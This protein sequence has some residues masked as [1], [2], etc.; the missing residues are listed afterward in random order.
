MKTVKYPV[1]FLL[2]FLLLGPSVSNANKIPPRR[3]LL[4]ANE[5]NEDVVIYLKH[6]DE[7]EWYENT[8]TALENEVFST[9]PNNALDIKIITSSGENV[10]IVEYRIKEKYKYVIVWHTDS[11]IY[12]E[13]EKL[14]Y[15]L[16]SK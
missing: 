13:N 5:T 15:D 11:E 9:D 1:L 12:N 14:R 8:I 3:I 10:K 2:L 6:I 7:K 4:I 16:E